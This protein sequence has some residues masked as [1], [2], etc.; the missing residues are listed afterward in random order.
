M[1]QE[2]RIKVSYCEDIRWVIPEEVPKLREH[3]E[4]LIQYFLEKG[5][6]KELVKK[7]FG[8]RVLKE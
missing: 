5:Y 3:S 1:D 7:L 6:P 2:K 4:T 8:F